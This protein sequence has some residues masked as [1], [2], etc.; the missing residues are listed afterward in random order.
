MPRAFLGIPAHICTV[1]LS[2]TEEP[3]FWLR[4]LLEELFEFKYLD[5]R[6]KNFPAWS[7]DFT[8][9]CL[10][11]LGAYTN[12]TLQKYVWYNKVYIQNFC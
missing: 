3:P 11:N 4:A 7:E 1:C 5:W 6:K 9:L 10:G 8:K 2:G 12:L